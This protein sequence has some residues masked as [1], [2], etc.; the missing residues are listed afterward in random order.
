MLSK[1]YGETALNQSFHKVTYKIKQDND[2]KETTT[3]LDNRR[4]T[5]SRVKSTRQ[6]QDENA[7]NK[8]VFR[9][10]AKLKNEHA[11][12][13]RS[14]NAGLSVKTTLTVAPNPS[15][16]L[17]KDTASKVL[18]DKRA[19]TS[20]SPTRKVNKGVKPP[21]NGRKNIETKKINKLP[22]KKE[23]GKRDV[24]VKS[25]KN[26]KP[27][28]RNDHGRLK[29]QNTDQIRSM[30][31]L[32]HY[33]N[34]ISPSAHT[35]EKIVIVE[36]IVPDGDEFPEFAA[37]EDEFA[38]GEEERTVGLA[39]KSAMGYLDKRQRCKVAL[40]CRTGLQVFLSKA[41]R[42]IDEK[43]VGI[44]EEVKGIRVASEESVEKEF[45][46]GEE[47][48]RIEEC[49]IVKADK[50][51]RDLLCFLLFA[52]EEKE[53]SWESISALILEKVQRGELKEYISKLVTRSTPTIGAI[54]AMKKHLERNPK[55][56]ET[57]QDPT[58]NSLRSAVVKAMKFYGVIEP[59]ARQKLVQLKDLAKRLADVKG[60]IENIAKSLDIKV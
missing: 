10:V 3:F 36:P 4:N 52:V 49:S 59:N 43:L 51:V 56:L 5:L 26:F 31:D 27:L 42:N 7:R 54:N 23:V 20:A 24:T 37:A 41:Q 47:M 60:R 8:E 38:A 17:T 55:W 57:S 21:C 9:T 6:E 25:T 1:S 53:L 44:R 30:K 18:T 50:S 14:R 39:L 22:I 35:G 32:S 33:S 40:T 46:I 16:A 58:H 34:L 2:K 48:E 15:K 11:A 13:S 19:S 28:T 12:S 45:D 29:K